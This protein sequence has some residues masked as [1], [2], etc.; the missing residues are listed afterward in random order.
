MLLNTPFYIVCNTDVTLFI[1]YT[2]K[3]IEKV[4]NSC[5]AVEPASPDKPSLSRL[6]E[7]G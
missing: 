1:F 6:V 4:Q 3:N 5:F 7:A 2:F